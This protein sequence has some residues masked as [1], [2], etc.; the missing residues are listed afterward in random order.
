MKGEEVF[1]KYRKKENGKKAPKQR[2]VVL[3][4]VV[5]V[6]KNENKYKIEF[7]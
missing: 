1:I 6:G 4:E 7:K 3:G 5:K 2:Y